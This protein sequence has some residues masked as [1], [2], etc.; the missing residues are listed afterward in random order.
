MAPK[1]LE[2]QTHKNADIWAPD[3]LGNFS[4]AFHFCHT[5]P[6]IHLLQ[7]PFSVILLSLAVW[8]PKSPVTATIKFWRC[9]LEFQFDLLK[10]Y[11]INL[12][13]LCFTSYPTVGPLTVP[14]PSKKNP[15]IRN[16]YFWK[17]IHF[18]HH[19]HHNEQTLSISVQGIEIFHSS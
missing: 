12:F 19:N 14:S 3:E 11:F 10:T 16:S 4:Q 15:K 2:A 1:T 6:E 7:I 13:Y 9:N 5:V 18:S 8:R 17:A